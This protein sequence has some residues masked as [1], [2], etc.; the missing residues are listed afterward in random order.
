MISIRKHRE[1]MKMTQ[2]QLAVLC[3]VGKTA[4]SMWE[5]GERKPDIIMLKKLAG[6][7]GCTADDL[8]EP[9]IMKKEEN[10]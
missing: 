9:I 8:L 4:V 5:T 1:Q 3:G 2:A 6:I 10:A 7:F